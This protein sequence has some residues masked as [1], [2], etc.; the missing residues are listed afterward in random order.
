M[1]EEL[2]KDREEGLELAEE[3]GGGRRRLIIGVVA[4]VVLLAV[5]TG[6]ALYL[7][8]MVG[9]ADDAG[10]EAGE[11]ALPRAPEPAIYVDLDP[12]FTVN[13]KGKSRA[14]YLQVAIQL[15]TR[16]PKV[17]EAVKAH[18]PAIRNELVLLLGDRTSQQLKDRAGKEQ[19][20]QDV[21]E[22]VRSVLKEATGK[23]GVENVLFT[24]F[25]MQ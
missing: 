11:S 22:S 7:T 19:L 14:T 20:Q 16:D 18:R 24:T 15:L 2:D 8:G 3:G 4:A 23:A 6:A 25:V 9:G 1:A 5:G 21:L 17:E 10:A 13:L 12:P